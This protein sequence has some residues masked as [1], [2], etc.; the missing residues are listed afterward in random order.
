M[1]FQTA[2]KERFEDMENTRNQRL[3][4]LQVDELEQLDRKRD[5]NYCVNS[6][7][8]NKFTVK[9]QL[10][11]SELRIKVE[12]LRSRRNKLKLLCSELQ[13]NNGDVQNVDIQAAEIR[14][15]ELLALKKKVAITRE[16]NERERAE[17][18]KQLQSLRSSS[19][20]WSNPGVPFA[21]LYLDP[22]FR[23]EMEF[24][25][26][27]RDQQHVGISQREVTDFCPSLLDKKNE[28]KELIG[29]FFIDNIQERFKS[30]NHI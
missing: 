27:V 23:P 3:S 22:S 21:T 6:A 26:F 10:F 2:F 15:L 25:C 28:L 7:E 9:T 16:S 11:A 20:F 14:N 17:L 12:E 29:D 5:I 19:W 8:I 4:L 18:Q 13:K 30:D 1:A 24:R